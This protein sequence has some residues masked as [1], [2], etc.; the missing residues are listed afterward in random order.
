MDA[1][2]AKDLMASL[3]NLQSSLPEVNK[4][5]CNV[6]LPN[7]FLIT[8]LFIFNYYSDYAVNMFKNF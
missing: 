8:L 3:V 5:V 7:S 4:Y 6:H 1:G 2:K